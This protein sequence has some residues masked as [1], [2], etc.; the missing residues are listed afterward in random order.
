MG[1][2]IENISWGTYTYDPQLYDA[3]KASSMLFVCAA[4]N[5]GNDND[6]KPMYPASYDLDNIISVTYV[7]PMGQLSAGYG[8]GKPGGNYGV[9][10]VD[11]AAPGKDILST[12]TG[13]YT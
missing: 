1:A 2:K 11:I 13:G 4:G 10:S 5:D 9:T 8:A 3:I 12:V 7:N 6:V